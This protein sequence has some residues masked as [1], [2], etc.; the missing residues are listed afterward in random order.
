MRN[1]NWKTSSYV[2]S[3]NSSKKEKK[4]GIASLFLRTLFIESECVDSRNFICTWVKIVLPLNQLLKF[5][6]TK[7]AN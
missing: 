7:L 3:F 4:K 1:R 2:K 5:S 6:I